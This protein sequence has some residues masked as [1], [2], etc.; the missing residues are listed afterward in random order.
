MEKWELR[1]PILERKL[2]SC[3][4]VPNK[5]SFPKNQD[6]LLDPN[7][8][9]TDLAATVHTTAHKHGLHMLTKATDADLITMGNGVAE[10]ASL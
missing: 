3:H 7:V 6:L 5:F 2:N 8:W 1:Q 4:V 10:K 9:I